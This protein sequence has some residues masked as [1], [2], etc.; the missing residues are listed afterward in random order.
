MERIA[1]FQTQREKAKNNTQNVSVDKQQKRSRQEQKLC[2]K[3]F[4]EG[5]EIF[6]RFLAFN[7]IAMDRDGLGVYWEVR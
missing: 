2:Q 4:R 5:R 7:Y 3:T 1:S 6:F